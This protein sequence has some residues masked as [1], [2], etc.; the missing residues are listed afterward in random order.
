MLEELR[1]ETGRIIAGIFVDVLCGFR[2]IK[3]ILNS[4][5][6]SYDEALELDTISSGG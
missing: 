2:S 6:E 4:S 3:W 5:E 1:H